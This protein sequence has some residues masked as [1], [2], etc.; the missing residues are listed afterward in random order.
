MPTKKYGDREVISYGRMSALEEWEKILKRVGTQYDTYIKS[1]DCPF[2]YNEDTNATH[3]ANALASLGHPV[4]VRYRDKLGRSK[5][6]VIPDIYCVIGNNRYLFEV[7]PAS[8]TEI[9]DPSDS[10]KYSPTL[11]KNIITSLINAASQAK[12]NKYSDLISLE[13]GQNKFVGIISIATISIKNETAE[14]QSYTSWYESNMHWFGEAMEDVKKCL[15]KKGMKGLSFKYF[16][17]LKKNSE[18]GHYRERG[19]NYI[20]VGVIIT[21][22]VQKIR[23]EYK[24]QR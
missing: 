14:K 13:S 6:T 8:A 22:A 1:G 21:L 15:I 9:V 7:K 20:A 23:E 2:F 4:L 24:H 16:L 10:S 19:K 17:P 12:K 5:K 3:I 18:L 11:V